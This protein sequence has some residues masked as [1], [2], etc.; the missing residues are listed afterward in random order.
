VADAL[1]SVEATATHVAPQDLATSVLATR[2]AR[3]ALLCIAL[4]GVLLGALAH[5]LGR[6]TLA[7]WFWIAGTV[8]VIAGLAWNSARDLLSGRMGV[9]AIA[10]VSMSAAVV[11]GEPL[12]ANVVAVIVYPKLGA[13]LPD[14]HGLGAMSRAHREIRHQTRLLARIASGLSASEIDRYMIRDAQRVIEAIEALVRLHS[15]QEA[16][17]YEHAAGL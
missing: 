17:I 14:G 8:P 2:H 15:A 1:L 6:T 5:V 3:V 10:L 7:H 16:D 12:A 4:G 9:D 11:L 13:Y